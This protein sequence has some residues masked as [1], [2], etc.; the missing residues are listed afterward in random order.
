VGAARVLDTSLRYT[1]DKT[2]REVLFLPLPPDLRYRAKP[3]VDVTVDRTSKALGALLVLALIKPWGAGL[4]WRGLS[5]ASLLVMLMWIAMAMRA[6]NE[7]L[8]AFRRSI[9][10]HA[11]VSDPLPL[12][13]ADGPTV[14]LLVEELAHPDPSHV[15]YAIDLLEMLGKRHLIT[16]LLLHHESADV[17]ARILTALETR[18]MPDRWLPAIA[19]LLSEQPATVRA[20]ALQV[21]ASSEYADASGV[22]RRHLADPDPR[23]AATAAVLLAERAREEDSC[24]GEAALK[25]LVEGN[26]PAARREVAAA[27]RQARHPTCRALLATLIRDRDVEVARTAMHSAH[28]QA[29]EDVILVP[30]LV[31]RLADR[32]L[33]VA[34]RDALV[35][36]GDHACDVLAHVLHDPDEHLW[37]RRHVPGTLARIPTQRSLDALVAALN[38]ADGFLRFK[39]LAALEQV[40]REGIELQI[41]RDVLERQILHEAKRYH[42]TLRLLFDLGAVDNDGEPSLLRR[43]LQDKLARSGDRIFRLLGLIYPSREVAAARRALRKG[44]VA[45]QHDD[46]RSAIAAVE[47]FDNTLSHV[48][49]KWV[50]PIVE[51]MP[52][53][54][55]IR[56]SNA[57]LN[58]VPRRLEDA[59]AQLVRDDDAVIAAAACQFA[60]RHGI[61]AVAHELQGV[62]LHSGERLVAN[63]AGWTL[64]SWFLGGSNPDT[65]PDIELA[66]RLRGVTLFQSATVDELVRIVGAAR[67]VTY[68]RGEALTI[69]GTAADRVVYLVDGHGA[70]RSGQVLRVLRAPAAL[71]LE[72]MLRRSVVPHTV[73]ALA[74]ATC[75]EFVGSDFLAMLAD[76]VDLLQ[77]FFRTWVLESQQRSVPVHRGHLPPESPTRTASLKPL[78]KLLALEQNSLLTGI[79][80]DHLLALAAIAEDVSADR[81]TT[82]FDDPDRPGVFY[83]LDGATRLEGPE[84][85]SYDVCAGDTIGLSAALAGVTMDWRATTVQP[86]R[87]LRLGREQLLQ[88]L[89]ADGELLRALAAAVI[90]ADASDEAPDASGALLQSVG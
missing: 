37:V 52:L 21:L 30:A 86:T 6:R 17:R 43:A 38:E 46:R 72:E 69:E 33:K 84:R 10:Q 48:L 39:A 66:D 89:T 62:Q 60:S 11:P 8:K 40:R 16:P 7:Y 45:R 71:G 13:T 51:E 77:G 61:T 79:G 14:E 70:M 31:A 68:R 65:L 63:A 88:L 82:L 27:L 64:E 34:A 9:E 47:Y 85:Q 59:L 1:I 81:G 90:R 44:G 42:G 24:R 58:D 32:R 73:T 5:F 29:A 75:L 25:A 67:R 23:I 54:D 20:A 83:L 3:F 53:A 49:R 57:L 12:D 74:S 4:G 50:M 35:S 22:L 78:E 55:R 76:D 87:A 18:R 2:T 26:L 41:D 15:I 28:M 56:A 36:Y 80:V 19:R